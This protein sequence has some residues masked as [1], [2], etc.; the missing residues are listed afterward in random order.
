MIFNQTLDRKQRLFLPI[1]RMSEVRICRYLVFWALKKAKGPSM[2]VKTPCG[3][4]GTA[5]AVTANRKRPPRTLNVTQRKIQNPPDLLQRH[6]RED[7][8][9]S[10]GTVGR[11]R[12]RSRRLERFI[13]A[14]A[15]K[16]EGVHV[17]AGA[18]IVL[19]Q[20]K[21][22]TGA[23]IH[24]LPSTPPLPPPP[25]ATATTTWELPGRRHRRHR[26]VFTLSSRF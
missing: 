5:D 7:Q 19:S 3:G 9:N 12:Q 11:S 17:S 15:P 8:N 13:T 23:P 18:V 24:Q 2:R 14:E 25:F 6:Q 21:L 22:P 26:H 1:Q 20:Q 16:R 10:V 4:R